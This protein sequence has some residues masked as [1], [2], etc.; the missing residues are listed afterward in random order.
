M[1][2]IHA[3]Q[4]LFHALSSGN[5]ASF[6]LQVAALFRTIRRR[7]VRIPDSGKRGSSLAT[8]CSIGQILAT[9]ALGDCRA[10]IHLK[11]SEGV[12]V[13]KRVSSLNGYSSWY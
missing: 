11:N 13:S 5:K 10:E 3:T 12:I 2:L 1:E 7:I 9:L 4:I 8:S 6:T